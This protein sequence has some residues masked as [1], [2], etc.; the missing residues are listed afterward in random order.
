[1]PNE[2]IGWIIDQRCAELIERHPLIDELFVADTL[3]W[4]RRPVALETLGAVRRFGEGLRSFNATVG[5]DFQGLFKSA[6]ALLLANA[7]RRIGFEAAG[8]KEAASS[9]FLTEQV[10]VGPGE[11][12]IRKNLR[13]VERLGVPP[14]ASWSFP[15]P[16][17]STHHTWVDGACR[18]AHREF[19]ILNL[20][21]GWKAKQPSPEVIAS[22]SHHLRRT[23]GLLSVVPCPTHERELFDRI[24][25]KHEI[26]ARSIP[27]S[28][29]EFAA[30]A[31]R[32]KLYVGG[33]TGLTHIAIAQRTPVVALYGPTYAWRNGPF[34]PSDLIM[35]IPTTDPG[36]Y[37]RRRRSAGYLN[38]LPD[39]V[40]NA[41]D[42]RLRRTRLNAPAN[43]V[44]YQ[45]Q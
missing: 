13:L 33:D 1:M 27:C 25:A 29:L 11:H 28:L 16:L 34:D 44:S 45:R 19:A 40:C 32:A 8:L 26:D 21:A 2:R 15:L 39:Q 17:T 22:A 43:L 10:E 31:A 42:L 9:M 37:S 20:S 30:L 41:I 23:H 4:R 24:L 12:V 35:Q 36:Y 6:L 18:E 7:P 38:V 5:L 14:P 3:A